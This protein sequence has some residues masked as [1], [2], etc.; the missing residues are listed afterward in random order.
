MIILRYFIRT[1]SEKW[2]CTNSSECSIQPL[3]IQIFISRIIPAWVPTDPEVIEYWILCCRR[4]PTPRR[5]HIHPLW[6]LTAVVTAVFD[7]QF[8]F[9][10]ALGQGVR[11]CQHRKVHLK[12][13]AASVGPPRPCR[14]VQDCQPDVAYIAPHHSYVSYLHWNKTALRRAVE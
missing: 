14:F 1:P 8:F 10:G 9:L 12:F 2:D 3:F 5:P 13:L 4:R 7:F 11:Y 6:S